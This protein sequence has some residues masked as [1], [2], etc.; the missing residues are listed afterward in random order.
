MNMMSGFRV[1]GQSLNG[2]IPGIERLRMADDAGV[3]STGTDLKRLTVAARLMRTSDARDGRAERVATIRRSIAAGTYKV[4]AS[5]VAE[6][7]IE[8]ML[9]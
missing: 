8:S 6:R 1:R 4:P 3:V 9:G 5:V 2:L 7:I